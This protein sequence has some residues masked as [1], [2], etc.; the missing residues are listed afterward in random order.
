MTDGTWTFKIMDWTNGTLQ[1]TET[2]TAAGNSLDVSVTPGY[3]YMA[4]LYGEKD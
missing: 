3:E 4:V 1:A 2:P